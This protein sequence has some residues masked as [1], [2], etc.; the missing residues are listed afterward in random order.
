MSSSTDR[1]VPS[2]E[3]IENELSAAELRKK[4]RKTI[5]STVAILVVIAASVYLVASFILPVIRVYSDVMQPALDEDEVL[6]CFN[7]KNFDRGDLIAFYYNNRILVRRV[8][9]V[10]GDQVD[11]DENGQV[12]VNGIA[13]DEPYVKD[14]S[15]Q[16][17]D[18]VLP[19]MVEAE[20]YFV[21]GDNRPLSSDS[22]SESVG[23]IPYENIVGK[24]VL[25]V[26]PVGVFGPVN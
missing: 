8:I 15:F 13:I 20:N 4:F 26:W 9:G 12:I 14:K 17:C 19:T 16:P 18:V 11:I 22:R 7:T 2:V 5:V 10:P 25:R 21:L 1:S 24:V 3:Q 6:V 23:P